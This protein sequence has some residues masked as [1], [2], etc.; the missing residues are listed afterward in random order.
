MGHNCKENVKEDI[1]LETYILDNFEIE[2]RGGILLN[3]NTL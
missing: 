2:V 3:I 1:L